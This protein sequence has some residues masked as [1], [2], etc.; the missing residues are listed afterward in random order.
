MPTL[1]PV[2]LA[3]LPIGT[4]N[5]QAYA[6]NAGA[7]DTIVNGV[8][9]VPSRTGKSLLSIDE[10]MRRIGYETPVAFASGISVSRATQTVVSGGL[11]YH[12]N[13]VSLPFTTTSTF[14]AA[15]WLM[16][17]N[18]STQDLASQSAGKGMSLLGVQDAAD[19]YPLSVT[20]GEQA[21][22]HL[23]ALAKRNANLRDFGAKADNG[24]TDCS[25]ALNLAIAAGYQV[26]SFPAL[27][28]EHG[29]AYFSAFDTNSALVGKT[30][31]FDSRLTISVPDNT[32]V[33]IVNSVGIRHKQLTT[34]YMRSLSAKYLVSPDGGD[35]WYLGGQDKRTPQLLPAQALRDNAGAIGF[36]IGQDTTDL[37]GGD[38]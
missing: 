3:A 38:E 30:L 15:Q 9:V 10:A 23:G 25:T 6:S 32:I 37:T 22:A 28:G 21:L 13:P 36:L 11:T 35:L 12:A 34:Y 8:G 2:A 14:N 33:G 4:T 5:A 18:V 16:V 31:D 24:A 26:I 27:A 1:D 29:T 17:S 20:N 7:L 19:Y